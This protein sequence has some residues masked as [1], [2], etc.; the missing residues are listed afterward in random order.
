[1]PMIRFLI[2][3]ELAIQEIGTITLL[4]IGSL[5]NCLKAERVS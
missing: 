3:D 2:E 1:M 4:L 5:I